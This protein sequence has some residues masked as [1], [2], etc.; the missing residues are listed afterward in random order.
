MAVRQRD[1]GREHLPLRLP[2]RVVVVVVEPA[3]AHGHDLRLGQQRLETLDA[4]RR[5]VRVDARGGPHAVVAAGHVDR[6]P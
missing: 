2:W 4:A 5:V 3:L 6:G 1:L